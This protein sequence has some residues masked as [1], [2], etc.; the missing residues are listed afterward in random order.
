MP[1]DIAKYVQA[2]T[3]SAQGLESVCMEKIALLPGLF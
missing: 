3:H 1:L 2:N